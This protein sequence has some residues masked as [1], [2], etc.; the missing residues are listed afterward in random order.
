MPDQAQRDRR[1]HLVLSDISKTKAFTSHS[2]KGGG[3]KPP[4]EL[5]RALSPATQE[6]RD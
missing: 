4:P 1:P 3:S 5:N 2:A 6:K